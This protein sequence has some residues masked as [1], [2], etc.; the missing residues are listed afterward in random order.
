MPFEPNK[1]TKEHVLKALEQIQSEEANLH[2]STKYDVIIDGQAF[3][4]KEIMR[5]AHQMMN[6]ERIW[7]PGGGEP[8]FKYLEAL[9]FEI[10]HV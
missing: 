4:P 8:T 5:Y 2:S 1:I 7:K 10:T 6:G 3:P 9:G